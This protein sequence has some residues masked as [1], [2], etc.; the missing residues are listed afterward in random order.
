MLDRLKDLGFKHS[1]LSG[2]SIAISDLKESVIK[3][4]VLKES[5]AVVDQ[6]N[7]QFKRGLITDQERYEKV[8]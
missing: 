6:I 8:V 5:Q 2:I 4:E 7:K 3:P 1:T